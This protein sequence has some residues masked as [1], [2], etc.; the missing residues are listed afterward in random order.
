MADLCLQC[1]HRLFGQNSSDF[2]GLTTLDD[3]E[4][5][6]YASVICEGC[7]HILVDHSGL[8][9]STIQDEEVFS[10]DSNSDSP[11]S[12]GE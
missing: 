10:H 3:T 1:T 11:G 7:G 12:S 5:G 4:N 9:V 8:R 2:Q 6:M